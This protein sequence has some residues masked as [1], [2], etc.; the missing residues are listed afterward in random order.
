MTSLRRV[1]VLLIITL[2]VT[3]MLV[4]VTPGPTGAQ[5]VSET[6]VQFG[7]VTVGD[8]MGAPV[9]LLIQNP[10]ADAEATFEQFELRGPDAEEFEVVG[11]ETPVTVSGAEIHRFAVELQ[12]TSPGP[13][14]AEL[15]VTG[16][17]NEIRFNLR[18]T[19]HPADSFEPN[20]E[21]DAASSLTV[22]ETAEA[23]T[24]GEDIDFYSFE[25]DLG[26]TASVTIENR[27]RHAIAYLVSVKGEGILQEPTEIPA[28]E[29]RTFDFDVTSDASHLIAVTNA[30]R[31]MTIETGQQY[32][33]AV[34]YVIST[35]TSSE[36][37]LTTEDP[38]VQQTESPTPVNGTTPGEDGPGFGILSALTGFGILGYL[39]RRNIR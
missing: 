23:I 13:K 35:A 36:T 33:V 21:I 22:G 20:D 5:G 17:G 12:P 6:D 3:V 29:S 34:P 37:G 25:V 28:G 7:D 4:S 18:G 16:T 10:T 39:F 14:S 32:N 8:S 11:L 26:Q 38:T 9:R 19:V 27:G 30:F 15:V 24:V 2:G 1:A 31:S